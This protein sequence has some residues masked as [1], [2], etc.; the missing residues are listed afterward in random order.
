MELLRHSYRIAITLA[1]PVLKMLYV[2]QPNSGHSLRSRIMRS[3]QF[4]RELGSRRW[5]STLTRLW[6]QMPLLMTG[7]TVLGA[8]ENPACGSSD[9]CIAG[10]QDGIAFFKTQKIIAH[11]NFVAITKN[12][13]AGQRRTSYCG[14]VRFVRGSPA[15]ARVVDGCLA[16]IAASA[17]RDRNV[18]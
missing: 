1:F 10:V 7:E 15:W 6:L 9:H 3:V 8:T 14:P 18:E 16:C 17:H 12:G 5:A 13:R 4:K 11:S 2:P